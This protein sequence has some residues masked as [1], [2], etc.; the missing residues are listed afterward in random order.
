MRGGGGGVGDRG[1]VGVVIGRHV[2]GHARLRW[3]RS[4]RCLVHVLSVHGSAGKE[5]TNVTLEAN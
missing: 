1:H 3:V 5:K 2:H 4:S